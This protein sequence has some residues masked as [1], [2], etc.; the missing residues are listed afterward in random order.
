MVDERREGE[1]MK[2][3]HADLIHAWADIYFVSCPIKP[4][5]PKEPAR[6]V[7]ESA[8]GKIE[9]IETGYC[10]MIPHDG[11]NK[12]PVAPNIDVVWVSADARGY[13]KATSLK[14]KYIT[15]FAVI[16]PVKFE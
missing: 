14:W 8:H 1:G 3:K 2:H 7:A 4:D 6:S 12:C 16:L 11:S 10:Q 9:L 15:H 13:T 5:P